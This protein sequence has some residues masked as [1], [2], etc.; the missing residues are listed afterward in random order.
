LESQTLSGKEL[1]AALH[2]GTILKPTHNVIG[3]VKESE[4]QGCIAFSASGCD[5]WI[6]VPAEMVNT[7]LRIG[8]STCGDHGHPIMAIDLHVPNTPEAQVLM[9]LLGQQQSNKPLAPNG[10][11]GSSG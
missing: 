9:A 6:D 3:I 1:M 5:R 10:I 2:E 7:A 8:W 11:P 4:K